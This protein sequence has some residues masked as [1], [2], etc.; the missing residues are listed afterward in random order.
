MYLV[1]DYLH[2]KASKNKI[3][4]SGCF[5]LSPVCNFS[6][7]MCYVRKTPEQIAVDG[8]RLKDWREWLVLAEECRNEGTLYLLL[9][10]GEPFIYPHFKELYRELHDMAF[11]LSI[12]S[13]GTLIDEKTVDWLKQASPSRINV[14]LY[15][16]SRETYGKICRNPDGYDRAVKAIL[17]LKEAGIPVVINASMIPENASDMKYIID[18]G[19][20]HG[21]NTR[22]ST[23]MFPP[24]KRKKEDDDSRFSPEVAAKMNIDRLRWQLPE[25]QFE[26]N[27]RTQLDTLKKEKDIGSEDWGSQDQY[28][29]CRAGRSSFW[30]SWDGSMSA[31]GILPFPV[32]KDP[33]H[34]PFSECWKEL[35]D[36][37][38]TTPVLKGCAACG[39][40]E[41]CNPCVAMLYSETS[42]VDKKAPYICRMTDCT[43]KG[44]RNELRRIEEK[45]DEQ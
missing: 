17:M 3:P 4:L 21:I 14:T 20:E 31:C 43:I 25:K 34:T 28:M 7:K 5:E 27:M 1:S 23:Y 11:V 38:R 10:G 13:N 16:A 24:T 15:G 39:K 30:V 36:K 37:V 35:T 22:V 42:S 8:K 40:K 45:T 41:I 9:T 6:C 29:R 12:N 19:K 26:M 32:V 2:K 33:F 18:F 44:F